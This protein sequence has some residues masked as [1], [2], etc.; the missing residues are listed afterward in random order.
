[1]KQSYLIIIDTSGKPE[2][3]DNE[4]YQ[5]INERFSTAEVWGLTD[6]DVAQ[7]S[8]PISGVDPFKEVTHLPGPEEIASLPG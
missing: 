1:M 6:D 7:A 8:R 2:V 3:L 5:A 4:V